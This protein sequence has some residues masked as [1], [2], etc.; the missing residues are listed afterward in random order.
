MRKFDFLA[1]EGIAFKKYLSFHAL[2]AGAWRDLG[3][4]YIIM[5]PDSTKVFAHLV[6]ESQQKF[7]FQLPLW[8][9]FDGWLD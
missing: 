7:F 5:T 3:S 9:F 2:G 1:H 6:T 4:S 8:I